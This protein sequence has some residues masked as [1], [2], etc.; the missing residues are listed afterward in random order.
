MNLGTNLLSNAFIVNTDYQLEAMRRVFYEV[1]ATICSGLVLKP[2][3]DSRRGI[4]I[5]H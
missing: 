4:C 5:E 1:L 3:K 2:V